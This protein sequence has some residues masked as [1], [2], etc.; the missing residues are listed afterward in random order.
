MLQNL[1]LTG[2]SAWPKLCQTCGDRPLSL[3]LVN[4]VI[5]SLF[6]GN[7]KNYLTFNPLGITEDH[8]TL[9]QES[10]SP[11]T[12]MERRIL[13]VLALA[14]RPVTLTDLAPHVPLNSLGLLSAL[15]SL[16]NRQLLQ[17]RDQ[18]LH[19]ETAIAHGLLSLTVKTIWQELIKLLEE[20]ILTRSSHWVEYDFQRAF[21]DSPSH[22]KFQYLW[23]SY[24]QE[25]PQL[26]SA[27]P[28]EC[29]IPLSPALGYLKTNW[30]GLS[31]SNQ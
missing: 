30:Q 14:E 3:L 13:T 9:V 21:S 7:V 10:L 4:A 2:E 1:G 8:L 26:L 18:C 12:P 6:A 22:P 11:L 17:Q 15:V 23:R 19:L 29:P 16:N 28:S 5:Q 25:K 24:Q 27:I 31:Q 20:N